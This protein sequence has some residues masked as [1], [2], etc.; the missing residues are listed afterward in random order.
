MICSVL[1]ERTEA[2]EPKR[3]PGSLCR[4]S[5][6]AKVAVFVNRFTARCPTPKSVSR[7]G[8][9]FCWLRLQLGREV[10][11]EWGFVA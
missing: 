8:R 10:A 11:E 1:A 6:M 4:V 9:D 5:E 3:L 7:S 2:G